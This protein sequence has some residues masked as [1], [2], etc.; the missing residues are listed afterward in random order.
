MDRY[1]YGTYYCSQAA[2]Q[3]GGDDWATLYRRISETLLANQ[4]PDGSWD[5]ESRD[6]VFGNV[7][8]SALVVLTLTPPYQL[9][10]IY[11]R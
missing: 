9:L 6:T 1:H 4:H 7:Y 2:F 3:L 8:S 10:P 11:Q 5:A